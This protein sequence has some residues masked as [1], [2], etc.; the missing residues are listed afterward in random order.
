MFGLQYFL[1]CSAQ[2]HGRSERAFGISPRD[3]PGQRPIHFEDAGSHFEISQAAHKSRWKVRI[4]DV[5]E[6]CGRGVEQHHFGGWEVREI[7]DG[8]TCLNLSTRLAKRAL[9][10]TDN[11]F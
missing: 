9:Q 4:G 11:R 1:R 6:L 10:S 8:V 5:G 7:S 3:W 2:V